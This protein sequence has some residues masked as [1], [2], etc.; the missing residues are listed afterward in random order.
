MRPLTL[1][2]I[3]FFFFITG[4]ERLA[5]IL[6]TLLMSFMNMTV[7]GGLS[8]LL[9]EILP[10]G[11]IHRAWVFPFNIGTWMLLLGVNIYVVPMSMVNFIYQMPPRYFKLIIYFI[12]SLILFSYYH[13]LLDRVF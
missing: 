9:E 10:T 12:L 3:R 4:N 5:Y 8:F 7:L 11:I 6:A 1:E 13:L 2:A